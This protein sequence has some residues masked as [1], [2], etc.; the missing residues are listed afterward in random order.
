MATSWTDA[1][2]SSVATA[3]RYPSARDNVVVPGFP[4]DL[5]HQAWLLD[6]VLETSAA[7]NKAT[8]LALANRVGVAE[9]AK[10]DSGQKFPEVTKA[11]DINRDLA[12]GVAI[13]TGIVEEMR[14][15]LSQMIPFAINPMADDGALGGVQGAIAC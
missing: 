9:S 6:R 10:W 12:K 15:R 7:G 14:Q 5:L 1:E 11:G 3:L 4:F 13:R 8:I 2:F